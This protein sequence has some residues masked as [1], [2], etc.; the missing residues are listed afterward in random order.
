MYSCIIDNYWTDILLNS[1]CTET[2]KIGAFH[3]KCLTPPLVS[4]V[5]GS[6]HPGGKKK[7]RLKQLADQQV[8]RRKPPGRTKKKKKTCIVSLRQSVLTG[9]RQ[10]LGFEKSM[11][12]SKQRVTFEL[13]PMDCNDIMFAHAVWP[14]VSFLPFCAS[15]SVRVRVECE[16]EKHTLVI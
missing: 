12:V 4:K 13:L 10:T 16:C 9:L 7:S 5:E 14:L 15:M 3:S 1:P 11:Q 8:T 2:S 6:G